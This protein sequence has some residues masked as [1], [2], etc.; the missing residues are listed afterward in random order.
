ME[1]RLKRSNAEISARV[2]A[3]RRDIENEF[4]SFSKWISRLVGPMLLWTTKREQR[5]LVRGYSYEPP[6]IIERRNWAG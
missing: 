1:R 3:L 6:V 4:G 2:H 5:R